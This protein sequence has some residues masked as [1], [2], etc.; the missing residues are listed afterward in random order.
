MSEPI[1]GHVPADPTKGRSICEKCGMKIVVDPETHL[2]REDTAVVRLAAAWEVRAGLIPGQALPEYT[3]HFF[4]ASEE[5]EED[6][7]HAK[8]F[9]YQP[10]FMKRMAMAASYQQQLSNPNTLNWVELTFIWY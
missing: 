3:K 5:Y 9:A 6:G 4:Y 7:R 2:W 10:I 1:C 8:E